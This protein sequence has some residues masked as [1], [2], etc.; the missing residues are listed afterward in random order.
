M[1][2]ISQETKP[3]DY[4]IY[5]SFNIGD[6]KIYR[7]IAS[8]A[9]KIAAEKIVIIDGYVGVFYDILRD[10]I[11][12]FLLK[13]HK[14]KADWINA[15]DYLKEEA[16]INS[17]I[18]PYLGGD[19]PIFG[20]RTNLS[21]IDFFNEGKVAELS[22]RKFTGHTIIY[23]MGSSLLVQGGLLIYADLPKNEIQFRSRAGSIINLG[24]SCP[25]DSKV[26][27]KRFYFID[28][29]V[30]NKHKR[31]ILDRIDIFADCQRHDDITWIKSPDLF[32]AWIKDNITGL[33]KDVINY[34]WSFECIVP[35]NGL[36]IESSG[37]MLEFSFDTLMFKEAKAVLGD[38]YEQF[39]MEFPIRFDFLDT[40]DGGN[41]SV[42][43]HPQKT[44]MKSHFGEDFTQEETY[45]ILD[46]KNDA[47]VYLGFNEN[48]D[49]NRFKNTLLKSFTE[50][51][52]VAIEEF[53]QVHPAKKHDLFLIPPGT[54]HGS[55]KDN[56]VLEISSTPYIFTFKLYDWVR[57]D[58]DGKPRPL[59][60][61]RGMA[62]LR[63]DRKG[64]KAAKELISVP[65]LLD[66]GSDWELFHLPTHP[67]HFYDV[68][69][70]HFATTV[71]IQT[72][73]KCHVLSLVEGESVLV[74]TA[75]G[76]IHRYNYAETFIIP[77]NAGV[78]TIINESKKNAMV[79]K[80]FVK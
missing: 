37:L 45:Y 77:A 67:D 57:P 16:E 75:N 43:C 22:L 9:E 76:D 20:T 26:M 29:I 41:L 12:E 2:V 27:Y 18:K 70:Y 47:V 73:N 61:E 49:R 30:L 63:F 78:Y 50:N 24:A 62:N 38:C 3:G 58:L 11:S 46:N 39:G 60:I 52:P 79:V 21:L 5:P 28:W 69:R 66:K 25:L 23:G 35:E 65:Q 56:L 7:G 17:L 68:H 6:G 32:E 64:L 19:D 15:A 36:L 72:E 53:V 1:P 8:L 54:I 14:I 40:F 59:N 55:G 10:E 33:N 51:I 71:D 74:K 31:T 80:A 48:I 13:N 44:Y 42:Q 4:N 34:A